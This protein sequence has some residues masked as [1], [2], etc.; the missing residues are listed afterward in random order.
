MA[1]YP[2]LKGYLQANYIELFTVNDILI[3]YIFG[4]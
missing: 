3:L 4:V 1:K 2:D